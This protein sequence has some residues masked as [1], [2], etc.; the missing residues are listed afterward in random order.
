[1]VQWSIEA[2]QRIRS[3]V[4][5]IINAMFALKLGKKMLWECL[6]WKDTGF[7]KEKIYSYA[8]VPSHAFIFPD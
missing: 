5:V 4:A 3:L 2:K 1:M 7:G 6:E 8:V